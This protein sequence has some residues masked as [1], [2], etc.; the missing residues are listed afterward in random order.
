MNL[1]TVLYYKEIVAEAGRIGNI[2]TPYKVKQNGRE[3]SLSTILVIDVISYI[4]QM[5]KERGHI[6]DIRA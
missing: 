6:N 3:Y 4:E 1:L 2:P 5:A